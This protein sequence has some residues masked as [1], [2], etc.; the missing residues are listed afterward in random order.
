M[1]GTQALPVRKGHVQVGKYDFRSSQAMKI[2]FDGRLLH[3]SVTG[4]ERYAWS[5]LQHLAERDKRNQYEIYVADEC[6]KKGEFPGSFE[7][8]VVNGP[9]DT[10]SK[11]LLDR[12]DARPDVYHL[13]WMTESALDIL[14]LSLIPSVLTVH[15]LI[16]Y[17]SENLFPDEFSFQK[18]RK[19]VS[20]AVGFASKI[21][22]VSDYTG[23]AVCET[24]HVDPQKVRTIYHAAGNRFQKIDDPGRISE[25]K[26]KYGIRGR[27]IFN[28]S[29]DYFHKNA[30]NLILAFD[31]LAGSGGLDAT[32][33]IAGK[34]HCDKGSDEIQKALDS[35]ARGSRIQWLEHLP[36]DEMC[37]MYNASDV[38]AFPSLHEGFGLPVLEAMACGTPVVAS[39]K[40]SIPE[41]AGDAALMVDA[42]RPEE[43]A[44]ALKSVL[45]DDELRES[46]IHKGFENVKRFDWNKAAAETLEVYEEL[47][48]ETK[49]TG[50]GGDVQPELLDWLRLQLL[51][52]NHLEGQI[53][54]LADALR[55]R[56]EHL[57]NIFGSR[58]LNIL[59]KIKRSF[60][61]SSNAGQRPEV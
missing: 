47:H 22:A 25:V 55:V 29:T 40:T 5:L 10:L 32:L 61:G 52:Y 2:A 19:A 43:L 59:R 58:A 38:F 27:F 60:G 12:Q 9:G 56:E 53:A 18:Y 50:G 36:E 14:L 48:E 26:E 41:V 6:I 34:R 30:R 4:V 33:V 31:L 39:D 49:G 51:E 13:T 23:K 8:K 42:T 1:N 21:I 37:A 44:N 35:S 7:A 45:T 54:E 28:L 17:E 24:F 3:R 20:L 15:D 46:L 57:E 11:A 16:L